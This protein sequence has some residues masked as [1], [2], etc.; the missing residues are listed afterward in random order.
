MPLENQQSA[1]SSAPLWLDVSGHAGD[2]GFILVAI[3]TSLPALKTLASHPP[4]AS[5]VQPMCTPYNKYSQLSP[6]FFNPWFLPNYSLTS[7]SA[8]VSAF[9]FLFDGNP[10]EENSLTYSHCTYSP[11]W[12]STPALTPSYYMGG[13]CSV[14]LGEGQLLSAQQALLLS[15]WHSLI[16]F[17]SAFIL[18]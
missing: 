17:H 10:Q 3:V 4:P 8:K 16:W 13:V 2:C 15:F 14:C 5:L 1:M 11:N 9:S 12:M 18:F 7:D 6:L